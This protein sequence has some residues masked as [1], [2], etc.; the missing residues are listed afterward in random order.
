MADFPDVKPNDENLR[1]ISSNQSYESVLTGDKKTA[2]LSGD[3]WAATLQFSNR[4]GTDAAKLRAW[5]FSLG[6]S[7]TRF[8]YSP[9]SI[10][11]LGTASGAGVVNGA[12]QTG[13]ELLTSGWDADQDNLFSAGDYIEVNGELKI[14]TGDV[15]A[16]TLVSYPDATNLMPSPFDP[17][18]WSG[19][20]DADGTIT[21]VTLSNPTG[22]PVV[23]LIESVT[24][25]RFSFADSLNNSFTAG[26]KVW[27]C[28]LFKPIT[29][30][31]LG[32]RFRFFS[33]NIEFGDC[34]VRPSN[35]SYSIATGD[36]DLKIESVGDGFFLIQVGIDAPATSSN[37]DAFV[38][39][40]R[41][42]TDGTS[43]GFAQIG[44]QSYVQAAF[45]GKSGKFP[46]SVSYTGT[47]Y[48]PSPFDPSGWNSDAD[49]TIT[50]V[51]MANPSGESSIGLCEQATA[52][53][54]ILNQTGDT[55]YSITTGDSFYAAFI[56][57]SI[58]NDN[59]VRLRLE[60][61]DIFFGAF[62]FNQSD[63][64]LI[65]VEGAA[66]LS[67]YQVTE[68][69]GGYFLFQCLFKSDGDHTE[70]NIQLFLCDTVTPTSAPPIGSQL[71]AQ[72]AFFG[73]ADD[74]PA[75]VVPADPNQ[76]P[77]EVEGSA[78]IPIAPKL[79]NSPPDGASI[80]TDKPSATFRLENDDQ[81]QFQIQ[82]PL[83]YN[84]SF[85]LLEDF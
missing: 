68:L 16:S 43:N 21:N 74:W 75:V 5:L 46:G 40:Y 25:D 27:T 30:P 32:A 37:V 85:S 13:S 11:N 47:N 49:G 82:G 80:I 60:F 79:R 57:K 76:F 2:E 61:D 56:G 48:M 72:A 44:D 6:G 83:I 1:L 38:Q 66:S 55:L 58:T 17:S 18:G 41:L 84:A 59:G 23:G 50:N 62:S 8:K 52:G 9:E 69:S 19:V 64:S 28:L 73:K 12:D 22:E 54:F 20:N 10:S 65:A 70:F 3:K 36:M 67:D 26:D 71:Y 53:G 45:F 39:Y 24:G 51:A 35:S 15:A 4:H 42:S 14:V 34:Y 33:D 78:L 29:D 81:A 63:G 31:S 77:A 7:R